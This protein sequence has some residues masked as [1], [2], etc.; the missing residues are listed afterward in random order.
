MLSESING[1]KWR[2][3]TMKKLLS[4][5]DKCPVYLKIRTCSKN[6]EDGVMIIHN[7]TGTEYFFPWDY[8]LDPKAFIYQIKEAIKYKHYPILIQDIIEN[9]VFTPEELAIKIEQGADVNN[10][11]AS[12]NRV[13]GNNIY[14]MDKAILWKDTVI[15]EKISK[16]RKPLEHKQYRYKYNGS[17]MIFLKKYRNGEFANLKEASESFFNDSILVNEIIPKEVNIN[18]N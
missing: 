11:P 6:G 13:V 12:E 16:D 18:E 10:L 1:E 17:L 2:S 7:N 9:H 8:N 14:V 15:L 4:F 5:G 3:V